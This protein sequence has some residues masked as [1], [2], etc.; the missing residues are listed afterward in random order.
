MGEQLKAGLIIRVVRKLRLVTQRIAQHP[1]EDAAMGAEKMLGQD[2]SA[3][4]TSLC[5]IAKVVSKTRR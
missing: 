2:V 4:I 5:D 1:A 3:G